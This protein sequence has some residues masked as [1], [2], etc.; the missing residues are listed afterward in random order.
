MSS[1]QCEGFAVVKQDAQADF[2]VDSELH[3]C[4]ELCFV[5]FHARIHEEAFTTPL[6]HDFSFLG[7]ARL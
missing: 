7:A 1:V 5:Y 4:V 3:Y 6:E 2:A